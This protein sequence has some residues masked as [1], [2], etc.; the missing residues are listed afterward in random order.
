MFKQTKADKIRVVYQDSS[1]LEYYYYRSPSVKKMEPTSGLLQGGTPIDL[2]GIWFDEKPEYGLFPFC[3][4]GGNVI[5]AK[6]IQ[7]TRIQCNSPGRKESVAEAQRVEV[8]LNGEDWV[9]TGFEFSYYERPELNDIKP[10]C[11]SVVGGTEIWLRGA[12]FSNIT[13]AMQSVLCRFTQVPNA[14]SDAEG[15][16]ENNPP[17]RVMPAYFVDNETMKCASPSGWSG[18]DQVHVDLTFNGKD[19][20]ENK[21]V[22]SYYSYFGSFPK[23]GPVGVEHNQA[24]QY[25]QVRGKG[26]RDDMSILCM[27]NGTELAP[28]EVHPTLIK[29]P[30]YDPDG[31]Q[32][33]AGTAAAFATKI[34]G[35]PQSFDDF[36]YYEQIKI[37]SV[38]PTVAPN[39]GEGAIYIVGRHFRDDFKNAKPACR[40]GNVLASAQL[41]DS[42]TIRCTLN[43]ELPLIEEGESLRVTAAL[44][45]YS[46][47][48]SDF[49]MHPYGITGMYPDMGPIGQN[50]NILVTGK[51]FNN[52]LRENARCKFGTDENYLIVEG[53]VLDDEHLICKSPSEGMVLP[54][55][56]DEVISVPFSIAFQEDL[57][58][59]YTCGPQ[60]FR[61]YKQPVLVSVDPDELHVGRLTEVYVY[62]SE[63]AP[64]WQRKCF[65]SLSFQLISLFVLFSIPSTNRRSIRSIWAQ[66]QIRTLWH[67]SCPVPQRDDHPVSDAKH[68]RRPCRHSSR[69]CRGDRR[70][71]WS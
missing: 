68:R 40:V 24:T 29:C 45:S 26:F 53:Q 6:F 71:E 50:T 37:E 54:E 31:E 16:D 47:A 70:N 52:E 42:E 3:R 58:F 7:T 33:A 8:S 41:L 48:A 59:P 62:A 23:S 12:K 43:N 49:S 34:D 64:F 14:A 69:N 63:Q 10:K 66:V 13:N 18:G 39:D 30:M 57:Y 27:L 38:T 25:I 21:F 5:R 60:K 61:M 2:T 28:F 15:M 65:P 4:I 51:G 56:A 11:G 32:P 36:Y 35:G 55:N 9:D 22:F 46:W 44:N 20:T 17:V 1:Q 19:Y 67:L